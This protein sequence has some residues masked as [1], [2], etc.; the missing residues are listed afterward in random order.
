MKIENLFKTEW[1]ESVVEYAN[2][3]VETL[4]TAENAHEIITSV[5]HGAV[6]RELLCER[7]TLESVESGKFEL[8]QQ[9][10]NELLRLAT[11]YTSLINLNQN[12][13]IEF[14]KDEN[15]EDA[16]VITELG[17]NV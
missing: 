13:I 4:L 3:I 7:A 6:F 10:L 14:T 15:G 1:E 8:T 5:D 2:S 9:N 17:L 11:I 12:G 16:F